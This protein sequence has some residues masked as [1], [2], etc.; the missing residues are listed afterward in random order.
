MDSSKAAQGSE[1]AFIGWSWSRC[2]FDSG[3]VKDYILDLLLKYGLSIIIIVSIF[4]SNC[5]LEL[6]RSQLVEYYIST[7][8]GEFW[9]EANIGEEEFYTLIMGPPRQI[10]IGANKILLKW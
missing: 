6:R 5:V 2:V 10:M 1:Y 3:F 7:E 9:V 4:I 8:L